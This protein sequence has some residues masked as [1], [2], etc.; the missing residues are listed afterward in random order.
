MLQKLST[1]NTNDHTTNVAMSLYNIMTVISIQFGTLEFGIKGR[2]GER[3]RFENGNQDNGATVVLDR[4]RMR[5]SIYK[6]R[7]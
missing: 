3:G 5:S 1:V 6:K 2:E 7:H 4:E